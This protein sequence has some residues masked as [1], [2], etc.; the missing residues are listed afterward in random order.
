MSL[1]F[2]I[3]T[4]SFNQGSFIEET[5]ES[6]AN[7][8]YQNYE[9]LVIDGGS[10]DSTLE[11]LKKYKAK[12]PDKFFYVSEK[13][14][15]QSDAINKGMK[16]A[17]G[18]VLCYLNSDDVFYPYTLEEVTNFFDKNPNACWVTGNYTII[19]E[20]GTEI[21]NFIKFYKSIFAQSPFRE[22]IL[23]VINFVNQPSTFWKREVYQKVG[24]FSLEYKYNMDYDYWLRIIRSGYKL[25]YLDKPLSKFRI[26]KK[27]KGGYGF[28]IQFKEDLEVLKN[29]KVGFMSRFLHYLHNQLIIFIYS[30]IK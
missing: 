30:I 9:H 18:D 16:M 26:H 23:E 17:K 21:Q 25:Y 10:T 11:I 14:K 29:N 19:D 8:T 20:N 4:P 12:Y 15:G 2:S 22:K 1:L 13:D 7:Q 6:I 3:V 28:K 5:I 24:D 27:S